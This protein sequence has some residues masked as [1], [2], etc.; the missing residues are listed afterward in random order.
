MGLEDRAL[1]DALRRAI[2]T[3]RSCRSWGVDHASCK[4]KW[5]VTPHVPIELDVYGRTLQEGLAWWLVWLIAKG[6]GHPQGLD[7][8]HELGIGPLLV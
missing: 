8:G 5:M 7:R 2:A 6:S 1:N 4:C 3:P